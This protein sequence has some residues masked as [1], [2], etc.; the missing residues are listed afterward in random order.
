MRRFLVGLTSLILLAGPLTLAGAPVAASSPAVMRAQFVYDLDRALGISPIYPAVPDFTDVPPSSPYYGYIEAAYHDGLIVGTGVNQF[1][2]DGLLTR[3]Q[4][5]KIEVLAAGKGSAAL[6]YMSGRTAFS[7][8]ASIPS[9]A[10]GYV[11]EA[12]KLGLVKGYPNGAFAPDATLTTADESYFIKQYVATA[13]SLTTPVSLAL[14][15]S[16]TDVAIGEQ[17]TLT[18]TARNAGGQT[19]PSPSVTYSSNSQNGYISG[20][21][22]VASQPG[23][24][25]VTATAAGG[26]S[27]TI[28]IGVYGAPSAVRLVPSGSL[29][30][31]G[32]DEVQM[33]V[34]VV[35][36]LGNVVKNATGNVALFY[37]AS[38]GASSIQ[39]GGPTGVTPTSLSLAVSTGSVAALSDGT[40]SFTLLAGVVPGAAD[41]FTAEEY[42]GTVT[43][44]PLLTPTPALLTLT[45]ATPVATSVSLTG[46][47]VVANNSVTPVV[48]NAQVLDQAGYPMLTGAYAL[49]ATLSGPAV[50]TGTSTTSSVFS[51]VANDNPSSPS[52][53]SITLQA[54]QGQSGTVTL[55]VS[56]SGV[57]PGTKTL[58]AAAT[59][60][61]QNIV[62]TA[63]ATTSFS[64]AQGKV[65]L[66]YGVEVTDAH[67]YPVPYSGTL[68]V[69]V[70][71][72][73]SIANNISVDGY[74]QSTDGAPDPVA[75]TNGSFTVQDSQHGA[76]AGT[77]T[78]VVMDPT[79]SLV[80]STPVTFT[81]TPGPVAQ[82]AVTAPSQVAVASPSATVTATL[83]DAYGNT[84]PTSGV[85]VNFS[86]DPGNP[87]PG[88][89]LATASATTVNGVATDT[90]TAPTYIG[91][92]YKVDVSS[93]GTATYNA[94]FS[95]VALI[96]SNLEIS[97]KN[98]AQGLDSNGTYVGSTTTAQA[99]DTVAITVTAVDASGATVAEADRVQLA[100]S[101]SGLVPQYSL[102]GTLLDVGT[103]TWTDTLSASGTD[104][105]YC[106]AQTAGT[107]SVEVSDLSVTTVAPTTPAFT[108]VAGRPYSYA[109]FDAS[110]TNLGTAGVTLAANGSEPVFI[111]ALDEYGNR[112]VTTADVT[113]TL[114][115]G[116]RGGSF[117]SSPTGSTLTSIVLAPGVTQ[118]PAYYTNATAGTYDLTATP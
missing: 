87:R 9:W 19:V 4:V 69:A 23:N 25:V 33:Q 38:G 44:S 45:A 114:G 53:T 41:Q 107:V 27:A 35:D 93:S 63:P 36:T 96:A 16:S 88:V 83:E 21:I 18:A 37:T 39:L 64:E 77:Y 67:G 31:D 10:R 32:Q 54:V 46:P 94:A 29:V 20:N 70:T 80:S 108:V 12:V 7:D 85:I 61:G 51:Y 79:G 112:T 60:A 97:F 74:Y 81:E 117:R 73:G 55:T 110:G 57:T 34:E 101:S 90:A 66:T 84:V 118:D 22:F 30:A 103:H 76:N 17:V 5:A 15:A 72:N 65:G 56:S 89:T 71:K 91:N 14:T 26:L 98:V 1:S 47:G 106:T 109:V 116:N 11:I 49:N 2:P 115:D 86:N 82:I 102:G 28:S 75:A 8:N 42:T 111:S 13:G 40:A 62:V 58:T 104:T 48:E 113:L 3:A 100:F 59:G 52:K 92:V 95:V 99:S 68:V 43:P 50:F 24:Y 105:I 6:A 78:I